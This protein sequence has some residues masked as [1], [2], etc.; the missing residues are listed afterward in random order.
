[1]KFYWEVIIMSKEYFERKIKLSCF[2]SPLLHN[3]NV[4]EK[5]LKNLGKFLDKI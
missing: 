2:E 3:L 5:Q 1:M 4:R